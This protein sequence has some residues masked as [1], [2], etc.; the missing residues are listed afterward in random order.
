MKRKKGVENLN[1]FGVRIHGCYLMSMNEL[2]S[3]HR[4]ILR[5]SL[6]ITDLSFFILN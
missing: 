4:S 5:G 1:D 2:N 3:S 6:D